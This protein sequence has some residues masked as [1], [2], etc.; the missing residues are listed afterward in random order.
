M[1]QKSRPSEYLS[2][3]LTST[4]TKSLDGVVP[5]PV[6]RV[7]KRALLLS[8]RAG[9]MSSE[10]AYVHGISESNVIVE[11]WCCSEALNSYLLTAGFAAWQWAESFKISVIC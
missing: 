9:R 2:H 8:T 10:H 3:T 4:L 5:I 6:Q 1:H 7:G 11:C